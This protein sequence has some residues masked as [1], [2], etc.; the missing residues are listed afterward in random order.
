M[1][2]Q[3]RQLEGQ[4]TLISA[5]KVSSRRVDGEHRVL[6][7]AARIWQWDGI[8]PL[9]TAMAGPA[10]AHVDHLWVQH[11]VDGGRPA[12]LLTRTL[13]VARIGWYRRADQ[14]IDLGAAVVPAIRIEDSLV[15]IASSCADWS[16]ARAA[17]ALSDWLAGVEGFMRTGTP[18]ITGEVHVGE[19]LKAVR[20]RLQNLRCSAAA[21]ERA[22]LGAMRARQCIRPAKPIELFPV[23]STRRRRPQGIRPMEISR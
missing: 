14:S 2:N 18:V 22:L 11:P 17:D 9:A 8:T 19:V 5:R 16:P 7:K 6:L 13:Y 4:L 10:A 3:L 21:E 20:H 12:P 23:P 15:Q 1:R